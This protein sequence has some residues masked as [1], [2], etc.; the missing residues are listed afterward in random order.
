M[1]RTATQLKAKIRNLSCGD[2]DQ[3][4]SDQQLPN[5]PM[6]VFRPDGHALDRAV[7]F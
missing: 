6:L 2:N 5:P 4:F 7:K 3:Q 1:I